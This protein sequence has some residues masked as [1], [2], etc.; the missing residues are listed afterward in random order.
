MYFYLIIVAAIAIDLASKI[1]IRANLKLGEQAEL[2]GVI[3]LIRLE[4]HGTSGN[5][6]QGYGRWLALVVFV[7]VAIALYM[8]SR[9][10]FRS[11]L[12]QIG[13]A[14][15]IGGAIGNAIDRIVYNRVTDYLHF[16]DQATMNFADIWVYLGFLILVI[17]QI[18][19]TS[20]RSSKS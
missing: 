1:A 20:R 11:P 7:L 4:N 17:Q 14:L 12:T 18:I 9:G 3:P 10:L 13:A 15:L 5:W 8:R 6:F 19:P 2:W 16:S